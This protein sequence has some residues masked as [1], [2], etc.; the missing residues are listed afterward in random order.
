MDKEIKWKLLKLVMSIILLLAVDS[1]FVNKEAERISKIP[2]YE[3]VCAMNLLTNGLAG[4]AMLR[5]VE[6]H[7]AAKERSFISVWYTKR[8]L[9]KA[10]EGC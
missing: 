7:P 5:G 2:E 9:V 3:Q 1:Y 10:L 8:G 4:R 6:N